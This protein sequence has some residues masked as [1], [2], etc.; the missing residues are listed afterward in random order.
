MLRTQSRK[1]VNLVRKICRMLRTQMGK[2]GIC[3]QAILWE[4]GG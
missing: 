4:K 3:G 1:I 2:R